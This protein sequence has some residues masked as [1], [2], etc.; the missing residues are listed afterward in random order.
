MQRV[1]LAEAAGV[2][3]RTAA[4]DRQAELDDAPSR[5]SRAAVARASGRM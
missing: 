3:L 4:V 5:T 2:D 1:E